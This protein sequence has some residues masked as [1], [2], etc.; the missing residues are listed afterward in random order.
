M[1]VLVAYASKFGSTRGVAEQVAARLGEHA[2]HVDI[3]PVDQVDDVGAYDAIVL[4]SAVF[5]Q[6]WIRGAAELLRRNVG[7]LGDRPVWLFSV[8]AFGDQHR[9]WGRLVRKEPKEIADFR[10]AIQPR[11]YRVFAGVIEPHR[12][13]VLSRLF[14]RAVGGHFGDNRDWAGIDAWAEGIAQALQSSADSNP[15]GQD[16]ADAYCA[17]QLR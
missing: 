3:L 10:Q 2:G 4:G 7:L 17:P 6:R 12:W 11:G 13:P 14:F 8:G 16:P 9:V 5:N 15:A 1:R